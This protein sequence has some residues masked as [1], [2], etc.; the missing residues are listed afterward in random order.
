MY[1]ES[2]YYQRH[3][4]LLRRAESLGFASVDEALR[5]L[6]TVEKYPLSRI[7]GIFD[8]KSQTVCNH[9]TRLNVPRR[10]RG[11][12]NNKKGF[13]AAKRCQLHYIDGV[14]IAEYCRKHNLPYHTIWARIHRGWTPY[15]AV[16]IPIRRRTT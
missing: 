16:S 15:E 10:S 7:G 14:P 11:G 4:D 2:K 6:Y 13:L 9:L 1:N 12:A 8:I 5:N 3:Q